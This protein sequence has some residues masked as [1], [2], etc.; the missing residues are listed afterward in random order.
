MTFDGPGQQAALYEQGIACRADWEAV[1]TPVL[2][3]LL[4]RPVA[5][6]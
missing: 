1:L 4:A 3:T 6:P 5:S 2:D